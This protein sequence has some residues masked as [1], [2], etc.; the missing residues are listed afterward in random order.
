LKEVPF[1]EILSYWKSRFQSSASTDN[2]ILV[3]V[4]LFEG[5]NI[6]FP[7]IASGDIE[8]VQWLLEGE[9]TLK[10]RKICDER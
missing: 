8:T 2:R 5:E 7:L 1:F 3:T 9:K 4:G 6:L 10:D